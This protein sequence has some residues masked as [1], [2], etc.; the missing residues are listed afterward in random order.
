M[1][2]KVDNKLKK[3]GT[4]EEVYNNLASR[5]AGN[6]TK[7]DI[8][9][10]T[11]GSRKI[12]ISKKLS[13]KM[14]NNPIFLKRVHKRTLIATPNQA[15]TQSTPTQ[16]TPT[17]STPTQSTPNHIKKQTS[18]KTQK[19][20]F[21]IGENAVKTIYY[22]ELNGVNLKKLKEE[23]LKEEAEEDLGIVI[24]KKNVSSSGASSNAGEFI[25]E[26]LPEIDMNELELC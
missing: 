10:K 20:S 5:T 13:E 19:L 22:P 11:I 6:L 26:E 21:K 17:Q 4:R 9:E 12:Y 16:S 1:E 23:L 25:I 18:T 2:N 3:V 7:N 15:P 14:I 24:P 8:I